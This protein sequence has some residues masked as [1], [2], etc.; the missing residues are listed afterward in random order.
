MG[1]A[2]GRRE[3]Q[4]G[5]QR[6]QRPRLVHVS[7][8]IPQ[9]ASPPLRRPLARG[10]ERPLPALVS[11]VP[12]WH[13]FSSSFAALFLHR[14]SGWAWLL[15]SPRSP[16][17]LHPPGHLLSPPTWMAHRCADVTAFNSRS[18]NQHRSQPS[19]LCPSVTKSRDLYLLHL[20]RSV[21]LFPPR[22]PWSGPGLHHLPP[23]PLWQLP[24]DHPTSLLI[25]FQSVLHASPRN[26]PQTQTGSCPSTCP[27]PKGS[28]AAPTPL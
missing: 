4:T 1:K 16:G 21:H 8:L 11:L 17:D 6:R 20:W 19:P 26:L 23:G 10:L 12:P 5:D 3:G 27:C 15:A 28:F 14:P 13:P 24:R 9:P 7:L 22:G 25:T 2:G 18:S